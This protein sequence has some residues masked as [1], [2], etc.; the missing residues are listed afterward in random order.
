MGLQAGMEKFQGLKKGGESGHELA[1]RK[2]GRERM[3]R[4]IM[5]C[6]IT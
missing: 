6:Q 3:K 2:G 4:G 1:V 5:E